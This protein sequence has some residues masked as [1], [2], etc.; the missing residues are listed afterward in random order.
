MDLGLLYSLRAKNRIVGG[1]VQ[2]AHCNKL[3]QHF[4][5]GHGVEVRSLAND[6]EHGLVVGHHG[7][8]ELAFDPIVIHVLTP[9][10][11]ECDRKFGHSSKASA[12]G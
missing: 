9:M 5:R 1:L 12:P 7:L 8:E 10:I 3:I 6:E 2:D 11:S 4:T